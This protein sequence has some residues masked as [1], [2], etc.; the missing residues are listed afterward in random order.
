MAIPLPLAPS[1]KQRRYCSLSKA[2]RLMGL[3]HQSVQR[4]E[5][6][7]HAFTAVYRKACAAQLRVL[8]AIE[9]EF[10]LPQATAMDALDLHL[11]DEDS[12]WA[13]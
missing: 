10:P 7:G 3:S 5:S 8:H 4:L 9:N 11:S 1:E 13:G 2:G 12:F 6:S